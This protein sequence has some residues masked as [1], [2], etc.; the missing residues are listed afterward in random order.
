MRDSAGRKGHVGIHDYWRWTR[1]IVNVQ[2]HDLGVTFIYLCP[3]NNEC[4]WLSHLV[5]E[6]LFKWLFPI[7]AHKS[8][9]SYRPSREEIVFWGQLFGR[10]LVGYGLYKPDQQQY[11]RVWR[12]ACSL[13]GFLCNCHQIHSWSPATVNHHR[14]LEELEHN[15]VWNIYL[16]QTT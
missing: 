12:L 13:K 7:S 2:S 5:A 3:H 11:T 9:C 14:T 4:I 8:C 16:Q 1:A 10:A 6:G 15:L